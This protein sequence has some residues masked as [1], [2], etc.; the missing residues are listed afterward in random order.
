MSNIEILTEQREEFGVNPLGGV[1]APPEVVRIRPS[2]G[3]R[4]LNLVEVWRYRELLWFMAVRD[5]KLRYKQTALGVA[6]AVMQPLL[7]NVVFSI[8]FGMLAHIPSDGLPYP[9]FALVAQ[10]PWQLFSYALTQAS[11]SLVAEQRVIT[12]VYFPRLVVP[13]ASVLSGLVDFAV[14]LVLVLGLMACY[15]WTG[16]LVADHPMALI[17]ALL[18]VPF[19]VLFALATALAVGLWLSA[20]NVQYRD[21]RYTIPFLAQ[22]WMFATPVAYSSTL[23]PEAWRPLYGLNPMAG[24]VESFRWVLLGSGAVDWPML[25]VSAVVVVLLL[26][27]GLFYFRRLERTFADVV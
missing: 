24:V 4:A 23:V 26:T 8:F 27:G 7:T 1:A 19:L 15:W 11:N 5:I 13:L 14:T 2:A 12:K 10:L 9:L 22:L 6:W 3:W 17:W 21:V 20:L 25:A 18:A 16:A